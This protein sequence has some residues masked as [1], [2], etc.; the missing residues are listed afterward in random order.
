M[1]V[2]LLVLNGHVEWPNRCFVDEMKPFQAI[3]RFSFPKDVFRG[4]GITADASVARAGRRVTVRHS[5]AIPVEPNPL[6]V[7]A[8]KSPRRA[9]CTE[10]ATRVV[11][12]PSS[13]GGHS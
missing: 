12:A 1:T 7:T 5:L 13:N 3:A 9:G 10:G 6:V 8:S 4:S 11:S 2:V